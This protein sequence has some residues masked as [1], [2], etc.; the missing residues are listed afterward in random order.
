MT[1]TLVGS[2]FNFLLVFLFPVTFN[3]LDSSFSFHHL[4]FFFISFLFLFPLIVKNK[5]SK[6][7]TTGLN[8]V[9]K[10]SQ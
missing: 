2:N 3:L 1:P 5:H 10:L 6:M 7:L 8:T 9:N 4:L